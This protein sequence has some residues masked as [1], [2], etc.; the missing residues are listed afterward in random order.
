MSGK[1]EEQ[2]ENVEE[3]MDTSTE[4]VMTE[5]PNFEKIESNLRRS[6]SDSLEIGNPL[7]DMYLNKREE[8][9]RFL[10]EDSSG[11]GYVLAEN[12]LGEDYVQFMHAFRGKRNLHAWLKKDSLIVYEVCSNVHSSV[13]KM[14]DH[15]ISYD[16]NEQFNTTKYG[17][18]H[19]QSNSGPIRA[20]S[21]LLMSLPHGAARIPD[22]AY[23]LQTSSSIHPNVVVEVGCQESLNQLHYVAMEYYL[24]IHNTQYVIVIKID[25]KAYPMSMLA[26]LY[27]KVASDNLQVALVNFG[28]GELSSSVV[29]EIQAIPELSNLPIQPNSEFYVP[30]ECFLLHKQSVDRSLHRDIRVDLLA[31]QREVLE[32]RQAEE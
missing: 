9:H 31:I 26:V 23:S 21:N 18:E 11:Q 25:T 19:T 27:H 10:Q 22:G 7:Y 29:A 15:Y 12:V 14:L 2:E 20:L 5:E 16:Y 17:A 24:H 6:S 8:I 1:A 13:G 28:E 30:I 32:A 4:T 3:T